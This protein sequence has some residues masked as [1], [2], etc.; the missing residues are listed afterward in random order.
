MEVIASNS[1]FQSR[2]EMERVVAIEA[3][4]DRRAGSGRA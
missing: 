4:E 2:K 3:G 1:V